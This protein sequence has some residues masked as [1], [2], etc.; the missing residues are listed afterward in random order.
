MKG[1]KSVLTFDEFIKL[2]KEKFGD[3]YDYSKVVFINDNTSVEIICSKH[4]SF[5]QKPSG[6]LKSKHGCF[7]CSRIFGGRVCKIVDL[8]KIVCS[9]CGK[10]QPLDNFYKSNKV[11]RGHGSWC[12]SCMSIICGE[13]R[14]THAEELKIKRKGIGKERWLKF[15]EE[16]KEEFN[17]R[18]EERRLKSIESKKKDKIAR[19]L[20]SRI[21]DAVKNG[22]TRPHLMEIL[23]CTLDE[24][25]KYIESKWTE[26][27]S[28]D[29]CNY[30]GWHLDHIIPCA[31][32][33]MEDSED[34]KR[35][36]HYTNYQPLWRKINQNKHSIYNGVNYKKVSR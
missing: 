8:D 27:M 34:Q 17:K 4:S 24:F 20:R 22:G 16:H 10:E 28:W 33:N 7:R 9:K 32:F 14:R 18:A 31:Y 21:R 30:Y 3:R 26:G 25:K 13:Y 15:K 2:A 11:K 29:N 23:G 6:H 36:F 1:I 19:R 35:C 12:K 5:W